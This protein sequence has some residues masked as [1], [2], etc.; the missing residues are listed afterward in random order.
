M[1]RGSPARSHWPFYDG[2]NQ[3]ELEDQEKQNKRMKK[4]LLCVVMFL[5]DGNGSIEITK[6]SCAEELSFASAR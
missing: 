4:I 5:D 6:E 3:E 2:N 1:L